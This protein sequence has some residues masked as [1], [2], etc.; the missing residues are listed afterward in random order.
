MAAL[1]QILTGLDSASTRQD[2]ISSALDKALSEQKAI[3]ETLSTVVS[4]RL[5]NIDAQV[6]L[7]QTSFDAFEARVERREAMLIGATAAALIVAVLS[8]IF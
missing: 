4:E 6:T 3:S 7:Q 2:K 8:F 1:D 5:P